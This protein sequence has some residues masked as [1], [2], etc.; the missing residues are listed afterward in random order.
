M[1]VK[2]Y[3]YLEELVYKKIENYFLSYYF[4]SYIFLKFIVRDN[5]KRV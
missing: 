3:V 4:L 5:D 1:I 2:S